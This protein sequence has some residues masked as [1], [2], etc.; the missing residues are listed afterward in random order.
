MKYEPYFISELLELVSNGS[1]R[2]PAFQ[3]GFV[4]DMDQVAYLMDSIYK[5][6]PFGSLLF[7]RTNSKLATERKLGAFDLPNPKEDYPID[8]V[9]DGQQRLTSIF[10]VFQ[11]KLNSTQENDWTGIY[12][13]LDAREDVQESQFYAL[14]DKEV[15]AGKHF[16]LNVLFDTVKYRSATEQFTQEQI[17]R[18]DKLCDI[19][20]QV[21]ILAQIL[22]TE[23]RPIVAIVFER[24]NRFGTKLDTLQLLSAWTWN[25]DFDLLENFRTL[26]EELEEFGFSEVGEDCDL[27]L[28]CTAAILKKETTPESLLELSGQEIRA[29]FPTVRNGIFG[30][31]DFM[32]RQL[33]IASLKNLPYPGLIIPLSA[34]FAEHDGKEISYDGKVYN[35]IKKWFWRSCFTNRYSIQAKKVIIHDIEE[36]IK[37]KNGEDNSFGE[38]ECQIDKDFF[39]NNR[40]R[41]DNINTKT[42]VLLLANNNPKSFLSGQNIDL[43]KVL[44]KYNRTEFHHI[45][46]KAYLKLKFE[47]SLINCL[48][49]FCFLNSSENKKI[50]AKKPSQYVKLMPKEKSLEYILDSALCPSNTFEDNFNAFINE[51]AKL[52]VTFA[53]TLIQDENTELLTSLDLWFDIPIS[54]L[55]T[56]DDDCT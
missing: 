32:K 5:K 10:S 12:F 43:D 2:I 37:L 56:L 35:Q 27:I 23:D 33:K 11:T 34:Y 14:R 6:Y 20:K 55:V 48:A 38:I 1:I 36:I 47:D 25:E 24:V 30:A 18:L 7:W 15:I 50:S 31:I 46:P 29:A 54:A 26:K 28:K 53:N 17:I 19:F 41:S 9:L 16:P 3:R 39:I 13:D 8:Y 45:Y 42:F 4:W 22:K 44:Q 52:L 49:N 40:F 51:R 21:S